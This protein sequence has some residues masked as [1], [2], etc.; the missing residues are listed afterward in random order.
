MASS[1]YSS[2]IDDSFEPNFFPYTPPRDDGADSVYN[3][4]RS[5]HWS[6]SSSIGSAID[7]RCPTIWGV[8]N[9][10]RDIGQA[11]A[12][13]RPIDGGLLRQLGRLTVEK[14]RAEERQKQDCQVQD[15]KS[16]M[17][18]R[19]VEKKEVQPKGFYL[20]KADALGLKVQSK[21]GQD[22]IVK[23]SVAEADAKRWYVVQVLE[24]LHTVLT[25]H[26]SRRAREKPKK[27]R[28]PS[29]APSEY[30]VVAPST[31]SLQPPQL[32][33]IK[34]K[35]GQ[36]AFV[37]LPNLPQL[38]R[39]A[40]R[41]SSLAP[42][43]ATKKTAEEPKQPAQ[44]G[45]TKKQRR[46]EQRAQDAKA[47][48]NAM[49]SGALPAAKGKK[50]DQTAKRQP[51]K[52]VTPIAVAS[53]KSSARDSA[54]GL[55]IWGEVEEKSPSVAS[56]KDVSAKSLQEAARNISR[57]S[58]KSQ[59][60]SLQSFAQVTQDAGPWGSSKPVSGS[61]RAP[62][63]G[64]SQSKSSPQEQAIVGGAWG[65]EETKPQSRQPSR[66]SGVRHT[67][68]IFAGKGWVTPHCLSEVSYQSPPQS[69]IVI[70]VTDPS[71]RRE[72]SFEDWQA[73]KKGEVDIVQHRSI[74]RVETGPSVRVPSDAA[75]FVRKGSHSGSGSARASGSQQYQKATV[76]SDHEGQRAAWAK[77]G[78]DLAPASAPSP[79]QKNVWADL[80][81]FGFDGARSENPGP[82]TQGSIDPFRKHLERI[83]TRNAQRP[84]P[85]LKESKQ[86]QE[87]HLAMP[88]DGAVFRH[89]FNN[90]QG[91]D[92][93]L[94]KPGSD[95]PPSKH[96]S[97]GSSTND[98]WA[99]AAA[100]DPFYGPRALSREPSVAPNGVRKW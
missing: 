25:L 64:R 74:S 67:T 8:D 30:S 46:E 18:E 41:A 77:F 72:L 7:D 90:A 19:K 17:S 78:K 43:K 37:Q 45:K 3:G 44:S 53:R 51:G 88:W 96:V 93:P 31:A 48:A 21:G 29:P 89:E 23:A 49:M 13:V 99:E 66:Q 85:I 62:S 6:V 24:E 95:R 71:Q 58:G 92:K 22:Q 12:Y 26:M 52:V 15:N 86:P 57:N 61:Q 81:G 63:G 73:M 65:G 60:P 75:A 55:G 70:P 38:S 79:P 47:A 32:V 100:E 11:G 56:N 10:Q 69:R 68:T 1:G 87:V 97:F 35:D 28:A 4:P 98:A 5:G 50:Q 80:D 76:K 54:I 14:H 9:V 2:A 39:A 33:R 36:E 16:V 83:A 91:S 20:P 27:A 84:V 82:D 42:P 34:G 59:T 40:S 94:S